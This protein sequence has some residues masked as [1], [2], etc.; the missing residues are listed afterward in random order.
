MA[1]ADLN[2]GDFSVTYVSPAALEDGIEESLGL[3][4]TVRAVEPTRDIGKAD[5]K[6]NDA[7]PRIEVKPDTFE[8][9]IDGEQVEQQ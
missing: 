7:L 2:A 5:M 3:R 9:S 4:R 1:F 8:I 6:N